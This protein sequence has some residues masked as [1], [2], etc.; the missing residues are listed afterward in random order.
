MKLK[1]SNFD[2]IQK[3]KLWQISKN[4]VV[5]KFKLWQ[6]LNS[7]RKKSK[8]QNVTKLKLWKNTRTQIYGKNSKTQWDKIKIVT[9]LENS[10]H[11]R[12]QKIKLWLNSKNQIVTKLEI[13][14]ISIHEEKQT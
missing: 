11:D 7:E 14:Q 5:K 4:Q 3:L 13:W 2:E 9:K 10:N 1:N 6:N 12:I 8:I